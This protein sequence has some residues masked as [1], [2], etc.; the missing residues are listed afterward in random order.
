MALDLPRGAITVI[1][2]V[3]PLDVLAIPT[4]PA[5]QGRVPTRDVAGQISRQVWN[6]P[7]TDTSS[8]QIFAALRDQIEADGFDLLFACTD[9]AC[10]GFD[11]R[12]QLDVA[13]TPQMFVDLG[14]YDFG[15]FRRPDGTAHLTLL[16]SKAGRTGY[17][18][19]LAVTDPALAPIRPSVSSRTPGPPPALVVTGDLG[20]LLEQNGTTV[21]EDL[22]FASGADD[23]EGADF[24]S[25]QALSGLLLARPELRIALVGHTDATGALDA[26]IALSKR[27][28][29]AVRA[30]LIAR[31]NV[32]PDQLE[33]QGIGFLAPRASNA[34][35]EGRQANRRVEAVLIGP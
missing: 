14:A 2:T 19:V 27:R 31:Y 20:A 35:P 5:Q 34:T 7:Q 13:P 10:G 29:E 17:V 9:R 30:T 21:L 32:P 4:G 6:L 25:L 22:Q 12:F 3:D 26:N 18:Q 24:A 23:L 8:A 16:V 15:S 1:D 28:A 11:F 33:A